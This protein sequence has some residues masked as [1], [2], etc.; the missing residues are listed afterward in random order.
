[1][2]ALLMY[3]GGITI[4]PAHLDFYLFHDRLSI[5]NIDLYTSPGHGAIVFPVVLLVYS[6]A[7]SVPALVSAAGRAGLACSIEPVDH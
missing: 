6:V 2:T 5:R 7:S 4:K 1:M 3:H